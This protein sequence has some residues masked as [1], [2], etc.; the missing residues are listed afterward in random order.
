MRQERVNGSGNKNKP[1]SS[2]RGDAEAAAYS[3]AGL[4]LIY[5]S[6]GGRTVFLCFGGGA[7]RARNAPS[8]PQEINLFERAAGLKIGGPKTIASE[9][10]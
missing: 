8:S 7:W 2:I 4:S 3:L 5:P 9:L 1:F 6:G 10:I